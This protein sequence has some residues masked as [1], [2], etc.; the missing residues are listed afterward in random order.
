MH[1]IAEPSATPS[2]YAMTDSSK[3]V[4]ITGAARRIGAQIATT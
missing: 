4:L 3:V 2:E 1:R